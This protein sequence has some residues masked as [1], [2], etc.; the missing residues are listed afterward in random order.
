MRILGPGV[1]GAAIVYAF[2]SGCATG[3]PAGGDVAGDSGIIA[4]DS[5]TTK[6]SGGGTKDS[7]G[8]V[9]DSGGPV[10]DS[11]GGGNCGGQ[12]L[13]S[14]ST[15]CNNQCVDITSDP[16]NCGGCNTACGTE[17]CCAGN[18]VD[19]MG[20]DN[21]NCGGCG[22]TC[23]G[24]CTNGQCKTGGGSCTVD[25]GSCSHSVCVTGGPLVED[26]DLSA[27]DA[28]FDVCDQFGLYGDTACCTTTW[29]AQCVQEATVI[30]SFYGDSCTGC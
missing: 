18:C 16:N 30:L 23:T 15:C 20:S 7:G 5:G 28:T 4:K 6:D 29:D 11:G 9:Q 21:A 3:G 10:Q 8:P 12:C 14:A 22:V 19:T 1:F 26:C 25:L 24:T 2:A 17:S 27:D 13:G